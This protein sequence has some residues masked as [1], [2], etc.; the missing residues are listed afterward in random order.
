MKRSGSKQQKQSNYPR[1]F[2]GIVENISKTNIKSKMT[3]SLFDSPEYKLSLIIP[4]FNEEKRLKTMMA[5]TFKV[6]KAKT[7]PDK[8]FNCEI[9]LVDDGSKDGT[10]EEYRQIASSLGNNPRIHFKLIQLLKNSGKGKAVS[11]VRSIIGHEIT[12]YKYTI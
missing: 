8:V 5:D 2:K 3:Q 12:I 6:L 11:E 1:S 10:V 9:I 4:A 7:I